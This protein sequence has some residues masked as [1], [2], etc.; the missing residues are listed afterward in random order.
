MI[1]FL[2][3][4]SI[5]HSKV[6]QLMLLISQANDLAA[7]EKELTEL[8]KLL[9][10][11][12]FKHFRKIFK[13]FIPPKTIYDLEDGYYKGWERV[14]KKRLLYK[15][16]KSSKAIHWIKSVIE[17]S[18][19]NFFK[20]GEKYQIMLLDETEEG[21]FTTNSKLIAMHSQESTRITLFKNEIE[22]LINLFLDKDSYV[23]NNPSVRKVFEL[24]FFDNKKSTDI[25]QELNIANSTV[26]KYYNN[27]LAR[28]REFMRIN[29]YE[30]F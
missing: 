19:R 24:R 14:L 26:T 1:V 12:L 2:L 22:F 25:A 11:P 23:V 30:E 3:T 21:G 17:N 18:I 13:S 29:G 10:E 5:N 6:N 16:E 4:L 20:N 8:C 28:L 7:V 15:Q 9:Q 27:T